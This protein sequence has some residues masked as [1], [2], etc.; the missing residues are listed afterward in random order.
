MADTT[1]TTVP[2]LGNRNQDKLADTKP[3]KNGLQRVYLGPTVSKPFYVKE[4]S[5]FI[6]W[7]PDFT[8]DQ[9]KLVTTADYK[10]VELQKRLNDPESA[11]SLYYKRI[12][13]GAK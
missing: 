10:M 11:E 6:D 7:L 12:L 4:G 8:E 5:V 3:T 2:K 13:K 1:R 9:L